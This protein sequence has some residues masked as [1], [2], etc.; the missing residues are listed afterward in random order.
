MF[1][2][3]IYKLNKSIKIMMKEEMDLTWQVIQYQK[4]T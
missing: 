4:Y 3:R 1:N 2:K